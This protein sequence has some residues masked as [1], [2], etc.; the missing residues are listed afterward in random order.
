MTDCSSGHLFQAQGSG[1]PVN[2]ACG[3]NGTCVSLLSQI[4][5]DRCLPSHLE[6]EPET[7]PFQLNTP[8]QSSVIH[9]NKE[10]KFNGKL[11]PSSDETS[12]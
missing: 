7:S 8:R 10:N 6:F 11:F 1:H 3:N 9:K 4:I 5:S 2:L 12:T